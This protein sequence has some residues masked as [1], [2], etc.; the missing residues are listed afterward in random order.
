[1]LPSLGG[2]KCVRADS[3]KALNSSVFKYTPSSEVTPTMFYDV[4]GNGKLDLFS[5]C[6]Q[7]WWIDDRT[8][9]LGKTKAVS[10][11]GEELFSNTNT[12]ANAPYQLYGHFAQLSRDGKPYWV[13]FW[14]FV[15]DM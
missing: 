7:Q 6:F 1:M 2:V 11:D 10:L 13:D 4:D 5:A 14:G 3:R 15:Y 9:I 8:V 12:I